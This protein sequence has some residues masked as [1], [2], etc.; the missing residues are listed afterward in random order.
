MLGSKY[1]NGKINRMNRQSNGKFYLN[2]EARGGLA[3]VMKCGQKGEWIEQDGYSGKEHYGQRE[4]HVQE[5]W[6]G[7]CVFKTSKE[8]MELDH[9]EQMEGD[10]TRD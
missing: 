8:P 6:G 3:N 4:L 10:E 2:S 1:S 7:A 5:P 9:D